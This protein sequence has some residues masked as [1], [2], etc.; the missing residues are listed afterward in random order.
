MK[1]KNH[2]SIRLE[3]FIRIKPRLGYCPYKKCSL[4]FFSFGLFEIFFQLYNYSLS[5]WVRW[6]FYVFNFHFLSP[7]NLSYMFSIVISSTSHYVISIILLVFL[8]KHFSPVS[9]LISIS[10]VYSE[11]IIFYSSGSLCVPICIVFLVQHF[12]EHFYV[13]ISDSFCF[14]QFEY[15]DI[16]KYTYFLYFLIFLNICKS[17]F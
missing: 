14:Y 16:F 6:D 17:W 9:I 12:Y 11:G 5:G 4:F 15:F 7:A 8:L 2:L 13:C 3:V 10:L 1:I